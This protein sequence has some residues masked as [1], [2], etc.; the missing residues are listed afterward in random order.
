MSQQT[1]FEDRPPKPAQLSRLVTPRI[2]AIQNQDYRASPAVSRT[3]APQ[4]P[5]SVPVLPRTPAATSSSRPIE[6]PKF[7]RLARVCSDE[8]E[9]F[10]PTELSSLSS[11]APKSGKR[12]KDQRPL[13]PR[14][15]SP[16]RPAKRLVC[17]T[18]LRG[19]H[20]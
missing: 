6:K 12:D 1:N 17:Y 11:P 13:T 14:A 19:R 16:A 3:P 15:Q 7:G 8:I 10:E 20:F 5:A 4:T 9:D 18:R 2:A